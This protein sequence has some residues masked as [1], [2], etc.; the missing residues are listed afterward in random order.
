M[1]QADAARETQN[2][3]QRMTTPT[4][5]T[6][7]VWDANT[8]IEGCITN[9]EPIYV[10]MTKMEEEI[11]YLRFRL[12]VLQCKTAPATTQKYALN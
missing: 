2:P 9:I 1:E 12:L 5:R 10:E 3:D 7:A 11:N 8:D 4:P 6:D